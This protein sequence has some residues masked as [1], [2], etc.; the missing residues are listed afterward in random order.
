MDM[1]RNAVDLNNTHVTK[2]PYLSR[3]QQFHLAYALVEVV[4]QGN[5]EINDVSCWMPIINRSG[6]AVSL[7]KATLIGWCGKRQGFRQK[8]L[9][10]SSVR[11]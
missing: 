10:R 9:P 5:A 7:S 1:Y 3:V 8:S 2:L 6:F 11:L 4:A